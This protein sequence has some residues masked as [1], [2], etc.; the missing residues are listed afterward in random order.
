MLLLALVLLLLAFAPANASAVAKR[1]ALVE[2]S[3]VIA[4]EQDRTPAIDPGVAL[5][6][7]DGTFIG[8]E[9]D[10]GL[11]G[12]PELSP[13]GSVL[14]TA[15]HCVQ[16]TRVLVTHYPEYSGC[17]Y[18]QPPAVIEH[19]WSPDGSH[20]AFVGE[21]TENGARRFDIYVI[22]AD[23]TGLRRITTDGAFKRDPEWR[24]DGRIAFIQENDPLE[25]AQTDI[26]SVPSGGPTGTRSLR[27]TTGTDAVSISYV[28]NHYGSSGL[29]Y[30]SHPRDFRAP[31]RL[32]VAGLTALEDP[33]RSLRGADWQ[34]GTTPNHLVLAQGNALLIVTRSG[35]TVRTL[36]VSN[37]RNPSWSREADGSGA[38]GGPGGGAPEQPSD[39]PPPPR[40]APRERLPERERDPAS[41]E[42]SSRR[43]GASGRVALELGCAGEP[44]CRFAV[45]GRA[46]G[47]RLPQR[48]YAVAAGA[49]RRVRYRLPAAARERLQDRGRLRARF[50]V[51]LGARTE[52]E[53]VTLR[54]LRG[55]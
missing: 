8:P 25:P 36:P 2:L 1:G 4:V 45:A 51:R 9:D 13:D 19:T 27:E 12:F 26:Y 10:W 49:T 23:H 31:D 54:P 18:G 29:A 35:R 48:R 7:T 37:P 50:E 14:A 53:R 20:L 40:T 38:G 33:N 24:V 15:F 21:A 39:P 30:V 5:L 28:Q 16:L 52:V 11:G 55:A 42:L 3:G 44:A 46:A 17:P 6:R 32:V 41:V 43:V 22:R 47:I 34:P